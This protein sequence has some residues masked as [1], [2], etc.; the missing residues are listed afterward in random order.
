M[1]L[2]YLLP[3]AVPLLTGTAINL[4]LTTIM[5]NRYASLPRAFVFTCGKML[6]LYFLGS[7]FISYDYISVPLIVGNYLWFLRLYHAHP[8][9]SLRFLLFSTTFSMS[10]QL[11]IFP[12]FMDAAAALIY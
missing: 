2:Y 4:F 12:R 7:F 6:W 5:G 9:R 3:V 11:I 8:V 10:A 1:G